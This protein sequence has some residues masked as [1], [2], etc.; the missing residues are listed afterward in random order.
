[1]IL[2][3]IGGAYSGLLAIGILNESRARL[4]LLLIPFGMLIGFSMSSGGYFPGLYAPIGLALLLVTLIFEVPT[5]PSW[6]R[7]LVL[8]VYMAVAA[9][10]VLF[11]VMLPQRWQYYISEP[12]F[13]QREVIFHPHYGLMI[14]D[15]RSKGFFDDVCNTVKKPGATPEL[16]SMPYSYAN[17]YCEIPPWRQ[18]VQTY[19]DTSSAE[20]VN[21]IIAELGTAPPKWLLYERQ[22]KILKSTEFFFNQ[23]KPIPHR[24]L[25]ALVVSELKTGAWTIVLEKQMHPGD[26][27]LLIRT[28]PD[29]K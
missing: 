12:M 29:A 14:V 18:Y 15:G 10:G 19:Y 24:A 27:W 25:D 5:T 21:R 4:I 7:G 8:T 2:L 17:Y 20:I 11:K 23:G 22:L 26:E 28:A 6:Q 16:L 1:M 13:V 3:F 9:S